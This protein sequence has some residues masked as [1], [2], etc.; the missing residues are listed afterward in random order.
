V[1]VS[2]DIIRA[3]CKAL[4]DAIE[5]KLIQNT[6]WSE[7][8]EIFETSWCQVIEMKSEYIDLRK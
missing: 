8:V 1:G 4:V 7:F 5:Y 6:D 2:S 3:S